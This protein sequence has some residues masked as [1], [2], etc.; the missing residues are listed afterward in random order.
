MYGGAIGRR[1]ARSPD[2]SLTSEYVRE[3]CFVM[4]TEVREQCNERQVG[5]SSSFKVVLKQ[6]QA[7]E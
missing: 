3:V 1:R 4:Y 5:D 7:R 2:D 6:H